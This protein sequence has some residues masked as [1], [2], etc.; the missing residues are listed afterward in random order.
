MATGSVSSLA[1][2]AGGHSRHGLADTAL[3]QQAQEQP[4]LNKYRYGQQVEAGK[5]QT[6]PEGAKEQLQELATQLSETW[7]LA[8]PCSSS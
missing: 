4:K 8:R 1:N 2:W 5:V 6:Q 3:A 7:L